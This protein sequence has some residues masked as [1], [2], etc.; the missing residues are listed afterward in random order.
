MRSERASALLLTFLMLASGCLGL[1]EQGGDLEIAVD[2]QE[3]PSH[4]DCFVPVITEDDCTSLQIFTGDYCR[5][6]IMPSSLSYGVEE[7]TIISGVEI[8]PLTPSFN[9]DGP[10]NWLVNPRLPDGLS[11]DS[12]TGVI[13][14][15]PE[16][17]AIMT[18]YTI[19]ASNA[20][21]QSTSLIEIEVI[22]PGPSSVQ[23][24]VEILSCEIGGYCE[25][26]SPLVLGGD[27]EF[28]EVEPPLPDG[29]QILEDGSIQG[30]LLH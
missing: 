14:G 19:I 25:A 26:Y 29:F 27:A 3:N 16:A 7:M 6:M 24:Q 5:T 18:G 1:F 15:I 9:G 23:Y 22:P 11:L 4:Q 21:G 20:A 17:R 10:Q 28:W 13:S 2:C 12:Q 30:A 8:Q